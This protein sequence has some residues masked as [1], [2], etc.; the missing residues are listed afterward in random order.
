MSKAYTFDRSWFR[1]ALI[2][3]LF[4][5]ACTASVEP[6]GDEAS[7][8]ARAADGK[9][10]LAIEIAPGVQM[11]SVSYVVSGNGIQ[12]VT[13]SMALQTPGVALSALIGGLPSG[14]GYSITLTGTSLDGKV[15]C[16]GSALFDVR[17]AETTPVNVSMTCSSAAGTGD[18]FVDVDIHL[19]RCPSVHALGGYPPELTVGERV[20]LEASARHADTP[21]LSFSWQTSSG[22]LAAPASQATTFECTE[23]GTATI[24]LTVSDGRCEDTE[25][26]SIDCQA[27][28]C[29]N[30]LLE[31]NASAS[32]RRF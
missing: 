19:A 27:P 15:Q 21:V 17:V 31:L 12:P 13:G 20:L 6:S 26:L 14:T 8:E 22:T 23:A 5:V 30:G 24:S 4:G 28:C 3:S 29:G 32:G 16:S 10:G 1:G 9:I 7:P 25:R 11:E 2:V 18:A